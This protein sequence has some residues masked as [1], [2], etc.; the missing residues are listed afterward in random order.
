MS[1]D[2]W[3]HVKD[4]LAQ[5]AVFVDVNV[6]ESEEAAARFPAQSYPTVI[7]YRVTTD[8]AGRT[9][10]QEIGRDGFMDRNTLSSFLSRISMHHREQR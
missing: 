1:R 5:D 8:G 9:S 6:Q 4:Q 2:S 10:L 7:G 3:P